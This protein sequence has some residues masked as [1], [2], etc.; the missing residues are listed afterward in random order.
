MADRV[1]V[2]LDTFAVTCSKYGISLR[3]G[4]YPQGSAPAMVPMKEE[5][6][7]TL[8]KR[9]KELRMPHYMLAAW[10][11]DLICQKGPDGRDLIDAILDLDE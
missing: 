7:D 4:Q 5:T 11:L 2:T 6:A 3:V 9:A 8:K 1:G 10:L